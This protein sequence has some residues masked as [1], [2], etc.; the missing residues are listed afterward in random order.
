MPDNRRLPQCASCSGIPD[1]PENN[2]APPF[3]T[4]YSHHANSEVKKQTGHSFKKTSKN[5]PKGVYW[6]SGSSK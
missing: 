6:G 5:K 2:N 3:I 4:L 1:E